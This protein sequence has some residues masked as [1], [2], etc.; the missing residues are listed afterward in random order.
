MTNAMIKR[1]KFPFPKNASFSPRPRRASRSSMI[2]ASISA[3]SSKT[4][5]ESISSCRK[6]ARFLSAS[7]CRLT[8][9]SQRGDSY[10]NVSCE[11]LYRRTLWLR[12]HTLTVNSP[13]TKI[14]AGKSWNPKGILQ[15][16]TP[17][18]IWI[19]TPS[20]DNSRSINDQEKVWQ[21]TDS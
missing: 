17:V 13:K 8:E 16:S 20:A 2:A 21:H 19:P 1:I 18:E 4:F 6:Y 7:S 14:P 3:I 5:S 11:S 15:M 10:W 9:A 12:W